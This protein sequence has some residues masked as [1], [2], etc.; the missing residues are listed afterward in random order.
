MDG[1][2]NLQISPIRDFHPDL[3]GHFDLLALTL[4]T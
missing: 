2:S 4:K 3:I 1:P